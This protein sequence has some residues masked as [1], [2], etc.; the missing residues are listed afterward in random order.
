MGSDTAT[1]PKLR[2]AGVGR[3]TAEDA[4]GQRRRPKPRLGNDPT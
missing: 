2:D 4:G 3:V 1:G